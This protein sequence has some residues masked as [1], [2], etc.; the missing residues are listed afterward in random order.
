MFFL[1]Q[2]KR[3][4]KNQTELYSIIKCYL[5][6]FRQVCVQAML[7]TPKSEPIEHPD[8]DKEN[9]DIKSACIKT[10]M[11]QT[12]LKTYFENKDASENTFQNSDRLNIRLLKRCVVNLIDLK[13][14]SDFNYNKVSIVS[15]KYN[16]S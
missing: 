14:N 4:F 2:N 16:L 15:P 3:V 9:N 8:Q 13:A 11:V 5:I 1:T 10:K 7:T 6:K 12:D